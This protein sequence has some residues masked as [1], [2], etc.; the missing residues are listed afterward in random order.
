MTD[1]QPN[2]T[3]TI[4][5]RWY[6]VGTDGIPLAFWNNGE[7]AIRAAQERPSNTASVIHLHGTATAPVIDVIWTGETN[8]ADTPVPDHEPAHFAAAAQQRTHQPKTVTV[9][10]DQWRDNGDGT[11]WIGVSAH[12]N[13]PPTAGE[14]AWAAMNTTCGTCN[15]DHEVADEGGT[16]GVV[17]PDCIDGNHVFSVRVE[18]NDQPQGSP[19]IFEHHHIRGVTHLVSIVKMLP[20]EADSVEPFHP[21][22]VVHDDGDQV[23]ITPGYHTL[24]MPAQFPSVTAGDTAVLVKMATAPQPARSR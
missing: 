10:E 19:S 23:L 4:Q 6:A 9:G 15:G 5:D 16:H 22:V 12:T 2:E 17:C 8:A 14:L 20:V 11:A 1:T 18:A 24:S 13:F 21:R 3:V 7:T